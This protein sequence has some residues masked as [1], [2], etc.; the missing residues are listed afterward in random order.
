MWIIY[1]EIQEN[2]DKKFILELVF[3]MK[4]PNAEL[5]SIFDFEP[6]ST[7]NGLLYPTQMLA[8]SLPHE[9][10]WSGPIGY[11]L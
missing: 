10:F 1:E 3:S 7:A 11:E 8:I 2:L 6:I 5:N 4:M 9:L